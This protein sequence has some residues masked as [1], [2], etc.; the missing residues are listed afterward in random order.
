[1]RKPSRYFLLTD[2]HQEQL[3]RRFDESLAGWA[4]AWGFQGGNEGRFTAV[5]IEPARDYAG[6]SGWC[7]LTLSGEPVAWIE[8]P[9]DPGVLL[10]RL[11]GGNGEKAGEA[12]RQV[13]Q[14]L[15]ADLIVRFYGADPRHLQVQG[16][17]SA[18]PDPELFR[19]GGD[20]F[21]ARFSVDAV[22]LTLL[23]RGESVRSFAPGPA[24][25]QASGAILP[26]GKAIETQSAALT[27]SIE[28]PGGVLLDEI[29]D[30]AEGHILLL[31]QSL[32]AEWQVLGPGGDRIGRCRPGRKGEHF[33][34]QLVAA[35]K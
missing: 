33:A 3:S 1:M 30:L 6:S 22:Q 26:L 32:T 31:D 2:T 34:V 20:A 10:D 29:S 15:I 24:A 18:R 14:R 8:W 25:R 4:Q 19:A 28:V 7:A 27:V 17:D 35:G 16:T 9:S 23:I 13:E 12:S 21:I 5:E 11:S